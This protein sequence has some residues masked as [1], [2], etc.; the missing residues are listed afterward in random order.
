MTLRFQAVTP[1]LKPIVGDNL[2]FDQIDGL[3]R[4]RGF[5]GG[6]I[7]RMQ[8][9]PAAK[10]WRSR[11]P[12]KGPRKGGKRTGGL[13]RGWRM[14][15]TGPGFSEVSNKVKYTIWVQGPSR[16]PGKKQTAEMR[17]RGWPN[18]SDEPIRE[19]MR[20]RPLIIKLL[21][22]ADTSLKRRRRLAA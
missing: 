13:G 20:W 7:R 9:Y 6:M 16:G 1:K 14:T 12:T 11:V 17:R 15:K 3:L 5:A 19:W 2:L 4:Q 8:S 18:I 10:P 22:Q 21:T